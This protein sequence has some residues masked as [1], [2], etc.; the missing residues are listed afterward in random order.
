MFVVGSVGS[1]GGGVV[2]D[3]VGGGGGVATAVV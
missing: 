1:V 3:S 2:S